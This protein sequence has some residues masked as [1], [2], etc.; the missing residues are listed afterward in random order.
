MPRPMLVSTIG[1]TAAAT[2]PVSGDDMAERSQPPQW[3]SLRTIFQNCSVEFMRGNGTSGTGTSRKR[4]SGAHPSATSNTNS[5]SA[6][7]VA[8]TSSVRRR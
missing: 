6:G 7:M 4:H 5:R 3:G 1:V 8:H 2:N